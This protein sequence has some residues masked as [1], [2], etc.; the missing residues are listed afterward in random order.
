MTNEQKAQIYNQ[1]LFEYHQLGNKI[2]ALKAENLNPTAKVTNEIRTME[3]QQQVLM[4]KV[5]RLMM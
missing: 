4:A 5:Q 3:R 1:M 2:S